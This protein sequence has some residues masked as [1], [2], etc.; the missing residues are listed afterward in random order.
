MFIQTEE[1]PNPNALKFLPGCEV[2]QGESKHFTSAGER[3]SVP[4]VV[5]VLSIRGVEG[6]FL[7]SDFITVT[8]SDGEPWVGLKGQILALIADH[9]AAGLPLFTEDKAAPDAPSSQADDPIVRQIRELIETRVRPAVAMDGGEISFQSYEDG[10][11]YVHLRG[12]CAGCPSSSVTLKSGIESMLRHYVPEV[13]EVRAID[14]A[15]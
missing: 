8:K 6:L 9:F 10:V 14:A 5:D 15:A 7:G 1:T 3:S 2:S 12:S 11:V 13:I 4:F